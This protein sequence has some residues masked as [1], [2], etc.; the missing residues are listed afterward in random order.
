MNHST[1]CPFAN[2]DDVY[3]AWPCRLYPSFSL[4]W[5]FAFRD[6][7]HTVHWRLREIFVL[8]LLI[9]RRSLHLLGKTCNLNRVSHLYLLWYHVNCLNS[10]SVGNFFNTFLKRN[11][12]WSASFF[13]RSWFNWFPFNLGCFEIVGKYSYFS[14]F[15]SPT[16]VTGDSFPDLCP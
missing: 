13:H 11:G 8:L 1:K 9:F 12:Q 14:N 5:E 3:R 7:S 15:W 6:W 16:N 2:P 4:S 10:A